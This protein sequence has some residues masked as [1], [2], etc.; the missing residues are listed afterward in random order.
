[1]GI[2]MTPWKKSMDASH[3]WW[4][5]ISGDSAARKKLPGAPAPE[6]RHNMAQR[7]KWM[8]YHHNSMQQESVNDQ[9][10]RHVTVPHNIFP[11]WLMNNKS[12]LIHILIVITI[13][14]PLK[15]LNF[16]HLHSP[17]ATNGG[18]HGCCLCRVLRRVART[19]GG[20]CGALRAAGWGRLQPWLQPG[21]LALINKE[22]WWRWPV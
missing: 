13:F 11:L 15:L 18:H 17:D 1:M 22:W 20:P 16:P 8:L 7:H 9:G 4:H 3:L 5:N 12:I 14:I 21:K 19:C 6:D 10:K 2:W